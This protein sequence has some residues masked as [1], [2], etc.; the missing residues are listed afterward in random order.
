MGKEN[1][2]NRKIMNDNIPEYLILRVYKTG[3]YYKPMIL[4]RFPKL[5]Q[6]KIYKFFTASAEGFSEKERALE[7]GIKQLT[8][9][10]FL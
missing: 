5:K 10:K 3:A 6:E 1:A 8:A 9:G 4:A 2:V 7:F